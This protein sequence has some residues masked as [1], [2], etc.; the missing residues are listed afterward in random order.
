MKKLPKKYA[1]V[2]FSFYASA[3]MVLIVSGVLVALNTGLDAGYPLRLVKAYLL[4][5]PIAFASLLAVRPLVV[6]LVA[7]SV[8]SD[9]R[10]E[11]V[12]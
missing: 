7:A 3:I 5:W 6:K 8:A 1:G 9:G 12:T 10:S 11:T 4:T 2:L